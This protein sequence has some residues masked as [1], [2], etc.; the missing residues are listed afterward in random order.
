ML[1]YSCVLSVVLSVVLLYVGYNGYMGLPIDNRLYIVT[2][3]AGALGLLF[4]FGCL[5]KIFSSKENYSVVEEDKK[6][7][8]GGGIPM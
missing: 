7:I 2:I 8:I 4:H 3:V 5:F 1:T 6:V